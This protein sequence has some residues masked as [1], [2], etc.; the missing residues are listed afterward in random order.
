M[1]EKIAKFFWGRI[2]SQ[3]PNGIWGKYALTFWWMRGKIALYSL[4]GQSQFCLIF[5]LS[6]NNDFQS[7]ALLNIHNSLNTKVQKL[8]ET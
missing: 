7:E 4:F 2:A 5:I 3:T 1:K 8:N 6:K